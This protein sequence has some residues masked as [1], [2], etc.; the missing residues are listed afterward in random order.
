LPAAL[1]SRAFRF[2]RLVQCPPERL[3]LGRVKD[4]R[5]DQVSFLVKKLDL[6]GV[7]NLEVFFIGPES[8]S[9]ARDWQWPMVT[10]SGK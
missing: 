9:F 2:D 4:V 5:R 10:L 8:R 7:S 6:L 3:Q 1:S